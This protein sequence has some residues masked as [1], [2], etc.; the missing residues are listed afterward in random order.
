MSLLGVAKTAIQQPQDTCHYQNDCRNVDGVHVDSF[1][2][3]N[4]WLPPMGSIP[5]YQSTPKAIAGVIAFA[6]E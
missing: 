6:L 3:V 5:G 1:S 4:P 2:K